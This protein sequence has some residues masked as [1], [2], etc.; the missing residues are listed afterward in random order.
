M[1]ADPNFCHRSLI[2]KRIGKMYDVEVI[3]LSH[4]N[5]IAFE[6]RAIVVGKSNR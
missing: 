1:E 6:Q 4:Q 5:P 3:H 2:A